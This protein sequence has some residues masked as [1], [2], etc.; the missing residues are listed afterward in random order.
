MALKWVQAIAMVTRKENESSK[1]KTYYP[2]D[3]FQARNME[4]KQRL[5]AG[6]I[7][8]YSNTGDAIIFEPNECGIVTSVKDLRLDKLGSAANSLS[9]T[10]SLEPMVPYLYT[11]YYTGGKFREEML[12]ISFDQLKKWDVAVP[13]ESFNILAATIG[14]IEERKYTLEIIGDLRVPVYDVRQMYFKKCAETFAL[15]EA[16]KEENSRFPN[17]DPRLAFL[18]ALYL[19]PLCILALPPSW[20]EGIKKE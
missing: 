17:G 2:G 14:T 13:I 5:A 3:W 19:N 16:W 11:F 7:A 4:I 8:L 6:E 12:P 15:T 10:N 18:R 9:I 20:R 1:R